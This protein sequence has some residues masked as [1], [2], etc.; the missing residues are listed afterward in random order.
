MLKNVFVRKF[1]FK[2]HE[3]F[4]DFGVCNSFSKLMRNPVSQLIKLTKRINR[5]LGD[6]LNS[7]TYIQSRYYSG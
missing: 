7:F 2:S 6:K 5:I 4:L 1:A 3:K